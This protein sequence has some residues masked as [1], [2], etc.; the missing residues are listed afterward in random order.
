MAAKFPN[1]QTPTQT[2]LL[3]IFMTETVCLELPSKSREEPSRTVTFLA[4]AAILS[5]LSP[6]SPAATQDSVRKGGGERGRAGGFRLATGLDS[7]L[8]TPV[9][10]KALLEGWRSVQECRQSSPKQGR[11]SLSIMKSRRFFSPAWLVCLWVWA[12]WVS[13]VPAAEVVSNMD[14]FTNSGSFPY[15]VVRPTG[16]AASFTVGS[17]I[18]ELSSVTLKLDG[19]P[20]FAGDGIATFNAFLYSDSNSAP[21]V[22]IASLG[23]LVTNAGW[24]TF[25]NHQF[26]APP[27]VLL[28]S[29]TTYWVYLTSPAGD[30]GGWG[31]SF[32]ND[33]T[34]APGWSIGDTGWSLGGPTDA[35]PTFSVNAVLIPEPQSALLFSLGAL[36]MMVAVVRRRISARS[37]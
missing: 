14:G 1:Q 31:G 10:G 5:A 17:G 28:Y 26:D 24:F 18:Y 12:G 29:N 22:P 34:G 27:E 32:A 30:N 9:T 25:F 19:E 33:E 4:V 2:N 35:T 37:I 20:T 8:P 3:M 16:V 23:S 36:G 6:P 21:N 15:F 7:R 11:H 13:T